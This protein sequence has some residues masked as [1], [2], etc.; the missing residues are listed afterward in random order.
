M[1]GQKLR[2]VP[3]VRGL[4]LATTGVFL[5]DFFLQ[6]ALSQTGR[7]SYTNQLIDVFALSAE[8]V[9]QRGWL[10]QIFTYLFLHGGFWHLF[11]NMLALVLFGSELELLWGSREFLIYYFVCGL[12]AGI[13]IIFLPLVLGQSSGTTIGSSGAIFGLLLAYA[14]NWPERRVLLFFVIPVKIKYLVLILGL[15]SFYLTVDSQEP[16][17]ISHVGHLGGLVTGYLYLMWKIGRKNISAKLSFFPQKK[18]WF[19]FKKKV[20]PEILEEDLSDEE[21]LDKILDKIR[22]HGMASLTPAEKK[23]LQKMS[24][25]LERQRD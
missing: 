12:G 25:Q 14:V 7:Q 10:W 22:E 17:E 8:G 19:T 11:F 21:K 13:F 23:F 18:K 1:V 20:F 9:L 6:F 5:M 24:E 16:S 3:A 15:I 2:Y 4:L